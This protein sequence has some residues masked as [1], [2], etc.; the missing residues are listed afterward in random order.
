MIASSIIRTFQDD[1]QVIK[2]WA[3]GKEIQ[4]VKNEDREHR[5]QVAAMRMITTVGMVYGGLWALS[6]LTYVITL[7]LRIAFKL[8]VAVGMYALAHDVFL[9]SQN[10]HQSEFSRKNGENLFDLFR[11]SHDEDRA[12]NLTA[13]TYGQSFWMNLYMHR[14]QITSTI[15]NFK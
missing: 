9:M 12:R 7:P 13:G 8:A 5:I 1:L 6:I 4:A 10:A 2:C 11:S 14:D 3:T 15:N